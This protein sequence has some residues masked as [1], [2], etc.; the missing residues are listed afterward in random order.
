LIIIYCIIYALYSP[1]FIKH[2]IW[3]L[4]ITMG[5]IALLGVYQVL[6]NTHAQTFFDL[7]RFQVQQVVDGVTE[8]RLSGPINRPNFWGQMLAATMPL[9]VY[10]FLL[11]KRIVV[12]SLLVWVMFSLIFSIFYT[13]SRGALLALIVTQL[14]I[15]IE[16]KVNFDI[17]F[18]IVLGVM[19][20]W[21]ILSPTQLERFSSI[22]LLTDENAGAQQDSS[23][24][25]RNAELRAGLLMFSDSP[26]MGVGVS[27]YE[28]NYL[29]YAD[30]IGLETRNENRQPHS[31]Y[32]E[33]LAETGLLGTI[34]FLS[35]F[36][37]LYLEMQR[38][39]RKL[40]ERGWSE[41][42]MLV[43][44]LQMSV[45][46]YLI[47]S[48]F[49]HGEFIRLLWGL[50][51]LCIAAVYRYNTALKSDSNH[52]MSEQSSAAPL[53][54]GRA[55]DNMA[56][57]ANAPSEKDIARKATRAMVWNYLSFVLGK[58]L[59]FI[60]I[61]ILARLLSPREVGIVALA[62]VA[63]N[64]FTVLQ[65]LGLGAALIQRRDRIEEAADTVFAMNLICSVIITAGIFFSA[66]FVADYFDEPT[67]S[68][69]L[70]W[71]GLTFIINAF[72]SIHTV[73]LKRELNFHK[74]IIP[75]LGQSLIKGIVSIG[76]ALS[77]AGVW[78]LVYGQ[79][80]GSMAFVIL[81]WIV[82]PWRPR[83]RLN[84]KLL[85]PPLSY[86]LS[87]LVGDSLS[88][89]IDNLDYVIVR[90][91]SA[92]PHSVSILMPTVCRVS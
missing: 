17:V 54:R 86:G 59:L 7:S 73:L 21:S 44:A 53:Y 16:R 78:S 3:V 35:F 82:N 49:L 66:P 24:R 9:V 12:K 6:T 26:L 40:K 63:I 81:A 67:V 69:V 5:F 11:E 20:A 57:D 42:Y 38:L 83:F 68:P 46:S 13:Y 25:G 65:D 47:S 70:R 62:T 85:R 34:P 58:V 2:A 22:L 29:D 48:L 10:L 90:R 1:Q 61:S 87:V 60:S 56:L 36:A 43:T 8:S 15:V 75:D 64:Y 4:V 50:V 31:L 45:L 33:Q 32:V 30:R 37:I 92:R 77:G 39:R 91:V 88:A 89:A 14:F 80:A 72:G 52:L 23:F 41:E 27:N 84:L 71:L 55:G 79:I 51:A 28:A 18:V 19:L 74:K 76:L